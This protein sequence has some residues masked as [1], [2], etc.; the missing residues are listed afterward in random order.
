MVKT[1]LSRILGER[2]ISQS[3]LARMTNLSKNTINLIYND[4]WLQIR[5]DTIDKICNALDIDISELFDIVE[6]EEAG[7]GK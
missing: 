6:D 4:N 7:A 1:K 5:K 2:R 3:T